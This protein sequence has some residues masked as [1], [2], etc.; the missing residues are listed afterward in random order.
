MA[1]EFYVDEASPIRAP[2][3]PK[4]VAPRRAAFA[5][6]ALILTGLLFAAG[7][8]LKM[9]GAPSGWLSLYRSIEPAAHF[10]FFMPLAVLA[11]S[12]RLPIHASTLAVCL[13]TYAFATELVQGLIPNRSTETRDFVQDLAGLAAG[14]L[15]WLAAHALFD[16]S[17]RG[18]RSSVAR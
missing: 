15:I 9:A 13:V 12:A 14:A 17:R 8:P 5:I 1:S 7:N 18:A 3:R 6:Y 11:I 16:R 10:L 4:R 2:R